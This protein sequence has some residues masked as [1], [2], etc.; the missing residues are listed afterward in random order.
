MLERLASLGR[1]RRELPDRVGQAIH[2]AREAELTWAEIAAPLDMTHAG[3]LKAHQ[4]FMQ[5]EQS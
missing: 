5:K 4:R 1:E 3:A 2:D